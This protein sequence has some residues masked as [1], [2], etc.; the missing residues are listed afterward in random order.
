M[1]GLLKN[2]IQSKNEKI[3]SNIVT[4]KHQESKEFNSKKNPPLISFSIHSSKIGKLIIASTSKGIC[5]V[6]YLEKGLTSVQQLQMRFPFSKIKNKK[7]KIHLLFKEVFKKDWNDMTKIPLHLK[8]TEFQCK[9]WE[10]LLEIPYGTIT[11]YSNIAEKV[12]RPKAQRAVGTAIG[13]N[14]ILFLIPCHRV[15][16]ANGKLGGF[17]WGIDKKVMLLNRECN[18]K[19]KMGAKNWDPTFF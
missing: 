9:V 8:G 17:Y 13:K 18:G 6:G 14:P 10:A 12:G 19:K 5:Y 2:Q 16:A 4:V 3:H 1:E 7:N 11:T 15:V